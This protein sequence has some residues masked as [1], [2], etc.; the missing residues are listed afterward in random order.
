MFSPSNTHAHNQKDPLER[1]ET[2][3]SVKF[4]SE[5]FSTSVYKGQPRKELNEAWEKIVDRKCPAQVEGMPMPN[6]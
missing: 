2:R 4:D 5:L 6:V 3:S 1:L